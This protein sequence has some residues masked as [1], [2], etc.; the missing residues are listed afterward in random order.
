M[1]HAPGSGTARG[2]AF[3]RSWF[4]RPVLDV[5]VELLGARVRS[6]GPEGAVTVRLT[7]VEAYGGAE[8]PGSHAFRGRT[9]RNA[10]M[11]GEP[12]HLYV[13]RHLGLH[14][15][16][17]VVTASSG[18]PSAVLLRAGEV[19]EGVDL[20]RRRRLAKGVSRSDV[21]LARGPARLAVA[22]GLAMPDNG[23]DLLS[24]GPVALEPPVDAA[25]GVR[26]GP[27]VGVTGEGGVFSRFPWRLWL[28]GESTVSEYRPGVRRRR[29]D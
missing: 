17:N 21:D 18:V 26:T 8:D 11:F 24:G 23:A 9:A 15:C 10:V 7:E 29:R 16:V 27:R 2:P 5:A 12:G 4:A 1:S 3:S 28:D 6:V 25:C 19:V 13:Y 22:L 20:A 14:H